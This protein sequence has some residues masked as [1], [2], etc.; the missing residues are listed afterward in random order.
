MSL[1]R[2]LRRKVAAAREAETGSIIVA[3]PLV[4]LLFAAMVWV[5]RTAQDVAGADV[6]L[7]NSTEIA[8]KAAANQYDPNSV[9]IDP[10]KAEAAFERMLR[11]NLELNESLEAEKG[12]LFAGQPEFTLWIYNGQGNSRRFDYRDGSL[13]EVDLP[14][15]WFP[16]IFEV[17]PGVKVM[18]PEPG[19]VALVKMKAARMF[20][21]QV[22][23][24]R[25]AAAKVEKA[26]EKKRAFVVLQGSES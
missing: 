19:A 15:D 9:E 20:G 12:S 5:V 1:A 11:K 14:E 13:D 7:K 21:N 8:V 23:Y 25:W 2:S 22:D 24:E 26:A 3:L 6:V 18:P 10:Q 17:K 16:Q 4:F